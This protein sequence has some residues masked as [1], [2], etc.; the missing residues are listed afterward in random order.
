[1]LYATDNAND[2]INKIT[3]AFRRGSALVA[4]TP[5]DANGAPNTCPGP[6]YAANHLGELDPDTGVIT[7]PVVHGPAV[8]AQGLLFLP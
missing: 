6:G 5:C 8:A 1:V 2:T 4:V 3:G 7:D